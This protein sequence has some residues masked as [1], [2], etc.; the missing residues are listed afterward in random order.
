[1]KKH[2]FVSVLLVLIAVAALGLAMALHRNTLIDWWVPAAICFAPAVVLAALLSKKMLGFI[3]AP[4]SR[5]AGFALFFCV[6]LGGFYSLNYYKADPASAESRQATVVGKYTEE[7]YHTRRISRN[8]AVR[9]QPYTVYFISLELPGR[10]IKHM[11]VSPGEYA[12]VRSGQSLPLEIEKGL[13]GVP[14]I[15]NMKLPVRDMRNPSARKRVKPN[16]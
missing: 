15:K 7:H 3:S 11:E 10:R 2:I 13:L 6:L 9:G 12:K 1:M 4:F 16:L 14:V 8:R 5:L